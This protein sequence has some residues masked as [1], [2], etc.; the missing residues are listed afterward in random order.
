MMFDVGCLFGKE[1][2]EVIPIFG[3]CGL[4]SR[5]ITCPVEQSIVF[6]GKVC[7]AKDIFSDNGYSPSSANIFSLKCE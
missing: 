2:L 5:G 1:E 6:D 3:A 7:R 4:V